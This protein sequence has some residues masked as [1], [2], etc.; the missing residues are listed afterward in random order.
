MNAFA[1]QKLSEIVIFAGGKPVDSSLFRLI[2]WF[3][4]GHVDTSAGEK[5]QRAC[6]ARF[7]VD[8]TAV[9][10]FEIEWDKRGAALCGSLGKIL[11]KGSLP[12]ASMDRCRL[13]ND[14]I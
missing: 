1:R 6:E 3:P 2:P 10:S 13:G 9:I 14:T 12:C 11:V 5:T 7:A 8:I 4:R